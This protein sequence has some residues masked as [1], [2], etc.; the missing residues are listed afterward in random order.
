MSLFTQFTGSVQDLAN[1]V[2]QNPGLGDYSTN[3][4]NFYTSQNFTVP[5]SG[6]YLIIAVGAGGTGGAYRPGTG[7]GGGA[8]GTCI[9]VAS[10]TASDV[11]SLVIGAGGVGVGPNSNGNAGGNTT[12]IG[13]GV[14]LTASGGSGGTNVTGGAGGTSSG[15]DLNYTGG[16]GGTITSPGTG[17]ATGGG[18]PGLNGTGGRGGDIN[19]AGGWYTGGG[20]AFSDADDN[21]SNSGGIGTAPNQISLDTNGLIFFGGVAGSAVISSFLASDAINL[22]NE[23]SMYTFKTQ[24]PATDGGPDRRL[25]TYA[26]V[27]GQN[28]L[29]GGGTVG[30]SIPNTSQFPQTPGVGAGS[31][32]SASPGCCPYTGNGGAGAVYFFYLA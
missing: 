25:G 2:A 4:Y 10:L 12:V 30:T 20:S 31:N 17:V 21:T 8:G 27:M 13:T 24:Q 32:G 29:V 26:V 9:K 23:S 5:D 28:A 19:V 3:R 14:S 15:G 1:A 7:A 16:R 11:Y 6:N 22:M 18:A